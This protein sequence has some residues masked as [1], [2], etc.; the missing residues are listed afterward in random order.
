MVALY[1]YTLWLSCF[2]KL[3]HP[4]ACHLGHFFPQHIDFKCLS[5]VWV[6][7]GVRGVLQTTL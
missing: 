5:W 6:V 4:F 2:Y 7:D 1:P 3:N